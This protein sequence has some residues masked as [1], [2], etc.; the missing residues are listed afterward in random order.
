M[1]AHQRSTLVFDETEPD[2][3]GSQFLECD[4]SEFYPDAEEAKPTDI[5]EPRGQSVTTSC[6]CDADHAGCRATRRSHTGI[7][8]IVNRA[9]ILWYSKRQNTV[10]SSTFGSEFLAMKQAV[11]MVEGLRYK[12]R[13]MGVAVDGATSMFCDNEA[14]VNSA[15][16]PESTLKKRHNAISYHRVREAIAG[17]WAR[18]TKE[19]GETNLADILTKLLAGP[20]L[21]D[22]ISRILW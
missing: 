14:V 17:G 16:N 5:P 1:K 9:P 15:I 13:M 4:W 12:L 19:P 3:R 8:I 2:F 11:D 21:K 6:F 22:L 18:V 10:E 7:I 20:K